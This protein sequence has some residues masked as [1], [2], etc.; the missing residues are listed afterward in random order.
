MK[1][2]KEKIIKKS[3]YVLDIGAGHNPFYRANVVIEKYLKFNTERGQ[4]LKFFDYQY[5]IESDGINLPFKNKSFDYAYSNHLIEHTLNPAKFIKELQRISSFGYLGAPSALYEKIFPGHNYH[6][7]LFFL[8][9]QTIYFSKK[10]N[11]FIEEAKFFG[12]V[13]P[14]LYNH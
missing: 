3:E 5:V 8:K 6:K 13:F 11:K 7:Y 12:K 14:Y 1:N 9:N 4:N 10:S 2:N